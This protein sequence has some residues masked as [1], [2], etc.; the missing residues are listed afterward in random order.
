MLMCCRG[1][2]PLT[3]STSHCPLLLPS[4][5]LFSLLIS[6]PF[7][8]LPLCVEDTQTH[9][10]C[11]VTLVMEGGARLEETRDEGRRAG[12]FWAGVSLRHLK[13]PGDRRLME[14]SATFTSG[15]NK[16]QCSCCVPPRRLQEFCTAPTA[17]PAGRFYQDHFLVQ[18]FSI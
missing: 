13:V 8:P 15:L 6:T 5:L 7:L 3:P 9:L 16:H 17:G 10:I 12:S 2:D 1:T 4:F 18:S 11:P 14:A